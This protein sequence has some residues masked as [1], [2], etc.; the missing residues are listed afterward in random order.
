MTLKSINH[1]IDQINLAKT[2]EISD[3]YKNKFIKYADRIKSI[4]VNKNASVVNYLEP[5]SQQPYL[6]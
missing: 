5:V 4:Q 1:E 3:K 2:R 6:Y